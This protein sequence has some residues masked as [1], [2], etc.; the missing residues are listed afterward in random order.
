MAKAN[1]EK[2]PPKGAVRFSL[3]LSDEQKKAKAEI[4]IRQNIIQ[5]LSGTKFQHY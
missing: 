2:K 4:D 1:I 5:L 3:S